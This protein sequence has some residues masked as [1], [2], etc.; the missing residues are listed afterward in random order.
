MAGSDIEAAGCRLRY[1]EAGS[2]SAVLLLHAG[3]ADSGSAAERL[4][5]IAVPTLVPWGNQDMEEMR[6]VGERVATRRTGGP[7]RRAPRR[8]PLRPMR[9]PDRSSTP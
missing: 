9:V 1:E 2:G 6:V 5:E 4:G 8:G 7:A 3:G